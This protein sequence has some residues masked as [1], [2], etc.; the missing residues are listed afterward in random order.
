MLTFVLNSYFFKRRI[1]ILSN[2][3]PI[4]SK[5]SLG[6]FSQ[7]DVGGLH[8]IKDLPCLLDG[9]VHKILSQARMKWLCIGNSV[10]PKLCQ[11]PSCNIGFHI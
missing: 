2:R 8:Y 6:P 7:L 9:G 11:S 3:F 4:D 10:L 1:K 5:L